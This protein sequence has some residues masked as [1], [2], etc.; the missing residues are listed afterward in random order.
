VLAPLAI[1]GLVIQRRRGKAIWPELVIVGLVCF[2]A[3][4]TFG[5]T[6]YRAGAEVVIAVGAAVAVDAA[7]RAAWLRFGRR[8]SSVAPTP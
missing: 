7:L 2:T 6:R 1:A 5:V 4:T 3:A 8:R